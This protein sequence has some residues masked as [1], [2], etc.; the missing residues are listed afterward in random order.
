MYTS[1]SVTA[2]ILALLSPS[3]GFQTHHCSTIRASTRCTDA[4]T[5][6]LRYTNMDAFTQDAMELL[7]G[8]TKY[9]MVELPDSMMST[10][11]W[12][13][14]LCEFITDEQLSEVFQQAS[15]QLFVPACVAR[16]PNME[17]LK[18]GFV[19]FRSEEEKEMAIDLFQGYEVNGKRLKVEP[20]KDHEKYGRIRVP[21]KIIEYAV[22]PIKMQRNGLNTMRRA[23]STL[24]SNSGGDSRYENEREQRKARMQKRK[25]R[26]RYKNQQRKN[27][28][29]TKGGWL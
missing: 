10:T 5:T 22:G 4:T 13:G 9:E 25:T 16:K 2:F 20:I 7:V 28:R 12:V 24:D 15:E 21:G 8:G 23:T 26:G 11:L 3:W 14:N 18:Y 27:S 17:S 1:R 29:A 19:A 6:S